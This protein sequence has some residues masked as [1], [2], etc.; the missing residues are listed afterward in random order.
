VVE[1]VA[2]AVAFHGLVA[3]VRFARLR[4][5]AQAA[6]VFAQAHGAA[7]VDD[8]AL[9]V[10]E[11]DYGVRGLGVELCRVG[12]VGIEVGA[13]EL[14]RHDVQAEAEAQV[15]NVV[16]SG[17]TGGLHLALDAALAEAAGHDYAVRLRQDRLATVAG[18]VLAVH[19]ADVHA[20]VVLDG[21]V[22]QRYLHEGLSRGQLHV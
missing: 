13:G 15:G 12:I 3:A 20:Y 1:L 19:P 21:G 9:L 18:D 14:D 7:L 11:R 22:D 10:E 5:R 8:A 2:V 16:E 4:A 6:N 17:V